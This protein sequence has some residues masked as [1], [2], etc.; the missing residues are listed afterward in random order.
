MSFSVL[1][2][3]LFLIIQIVILQEIVLTANESTSSSDNSRSIFLLYSLLPD[4]AFS[5]DYYW[6]GILSCFFLII[7]AEFY[8]KTAKTQEVFSMNSYFA[9]NGI[10]NL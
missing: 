7:V 8:I 9:T 5:V 2:I 6:K 3:L 10:R 4:I 1:L